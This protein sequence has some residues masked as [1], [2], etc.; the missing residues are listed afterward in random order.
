MRPLIGVTSLWDDIKS[1]G[2]MWQNYLELIWDAGGMP[3]VLPLYASNQAIEEAVGRCSGFLF[4][5]GQDIAPEYFE[6]KHPQYCQKPALVRDALEFKLFDAARQAHR[7][8][9]GICRGM[10]LINVAMGGDL[11]EDIP[12]QIGTQTEHRYVTPG[13]PTMHEVQ[14]LGESYLSKACS[15]KVITVNSFHHQAI[16]RV[17]PSLKVIARSSTDQI[18]E[19]VE[20]EGEDFLVALQWHPERIY[21]GRP[22]NLR[23]VDILLRLRLKSC[24]SDGSVMQ[25]R[26]S[27]KD[28]IRRSHR[29]AAYT[30]AA[31]LLLFLFFWCALFLTADSG[32]F[33]FGLPLWFWLSCVGGYLLS[34][35]VVWFLVKKAFRHFELISD[36]D[37]KP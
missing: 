30:L 20:A 9:F 26:L 33:L 7:P 34:V 23:L 22:E 28:A 14:L 31:A 27:Y 4:T 16:D 8:I 13:T 12:S 17:A 24:F 11:I 21:Q 32:V 36:E 2:W 10:Q 19:A 18:V 3:M 15:E 5:G 6:S 25:K 1:C 35:V 29:E 37:K